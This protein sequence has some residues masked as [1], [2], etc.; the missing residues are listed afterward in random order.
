[1]REELGTTRVDVIPSSPLSVML[2][3]FLSLFME[4]LHS[5]VGSLEAD[6]RGEILWDLCGCMSVLPYTSPV[7][8]LKTEAG[9]HLVK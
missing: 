5:D 2:R 9:G 3:R 7:T 1:M 6:F 8:V 4:F